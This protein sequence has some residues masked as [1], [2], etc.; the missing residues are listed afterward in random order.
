MEAVFFHFLQILNLMCISWGA[1]CS[2]LWFDESRTNIIMESYIFFY[3]LVYKYLDLSNMLN[4]TGY[5]DIC[6][7]IHLFIGTDG[8]WLLHRSFL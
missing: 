2:Y 5:M 1:L 7:F 8:S 4:M 3:F 6:I